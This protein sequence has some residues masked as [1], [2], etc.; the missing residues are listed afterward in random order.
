MR[1]LM[2]ALMASVGL[3][4]A[5]QAQYAP[6]QPGG[7]GQDRGYGGRGYGDQGYGDQGYGDRFG[8]GAPRDPRARIEFLQ[9]R[10]D[11]GYRDGSLDPREARGAARELDRIR[12]RARDLYRRDRGQLSGGHQAE[13]EG[14][15]DDLGRRLR[16]DRRSY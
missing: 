6:Q 7:Y 15:L 12:Q 1:V 3:A 16:W 4:G 5:A 11:R 9:Q 2:M 8:P 10:I 13:I 14:R